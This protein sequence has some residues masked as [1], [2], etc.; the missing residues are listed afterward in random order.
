M[1]ESI[2]GHLFRTF[3]IDCFEEAAKL[4]AQDPS[5][6]AWE[7][8]KVMMWTLQHVKQLSVEGT[9]QMAENVLREIAVSAKGDDNFGEPE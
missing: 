5:A 1:K 6:D 9:D 4:F 7:H 8:L 3:I 2:R